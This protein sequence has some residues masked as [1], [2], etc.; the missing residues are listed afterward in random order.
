[1]FYIRVLKNL[2][3]KI[4][5]IKDFIISY[6]IKNKW[7]VSFSLKSPIKTSFI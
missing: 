6:V 7:S 3:E 5:C 2:Q 4:Y 1:M